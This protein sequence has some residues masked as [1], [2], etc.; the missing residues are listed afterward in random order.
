VVFEE[1]FQINM[2]SL[3]QT[4][5]STFLFN[6]KKKMPEEYIQNRT[7]DRLLCSISLTKCNLV[8]SK[9]LSIFAMLFPIKNVGLLGHV[10]KEGTPE[11][12][13][14]GTPEYYFHF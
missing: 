10:V 9:I 6:N 7:K 2:S 12:R 3:H 8:C 1:Y 14:A 4:R 13:N 11:C 5:L